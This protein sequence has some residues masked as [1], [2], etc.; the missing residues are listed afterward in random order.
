MSPYLFLL[1]ADVLQNLIKADTGARHP[2][3]EDGPCAVLQYADDTLIVCRGDVAD[4]SRLRMLLDQFADAT[5]LTINDS[6]STAV[7]MH[8]SAMVLPQCIAA[9]GCR[10]EGFPQTYLGLPLS[11]C[12]LKLSTFAPY[13]AKTDRYLAGWQATLLNP[14]G[15][16]V[17]INAV[18]DSQLVYLMSALP[19]PPGVLK[20][21]DQHRRAFLWT[22]EDV[23]RGANCLVAWAQVCDNRANGG[24]GIRDLNLQNSCLLLKLLHQLHRGA[25]SSWA[26]WVR[27]HCCIASMEG[28]ITGPHWTALRGLLPVYRAIT[29]VQ[30]G[31]G[32]TTS[33][34]FDVWNG[35]DALAKTCTSVC[36]GVLLLNKKR[37]P[38][39]DHQK[40][41]IHV[42]N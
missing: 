11:H 8:V 4:V 18:L 35:Q 22:G 30:L 5:G 6:K 15:R 26:G 2:I 40:K 19:I 9:L 27:K 14:M 21:V 33:S 41:M 1:V 7:P 25:G 42:G 28:E 24:L 39:R 31:D 17:L 32:G 36:P 12:K 37:T 13:I 38:P 16:T 3:A 10:E 29:T 20:Q 23:A 34:W